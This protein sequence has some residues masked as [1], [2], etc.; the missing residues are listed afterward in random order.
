MPP[1]N[2]IINFFNI[3]EQSFSGGRFIRLTLGKPANP[4]ADLKNVYIKPVS[5][6]SQIVLSFVY[7]HQT[8]DITKNFPISEALAIL[9]SLLGSVFLHAILFTQDN[10]I[11]VLFNKKRVSKIVF[12][13]PTQS[14]L[15]AFTHDH[16]KTRLISTEGNYYLQQLG[17]T[18][19]KFEV[20]P[21]DAG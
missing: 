9:K 15:Q 19:T 2:E 17:L 3:F 1:E 16:Q 5:I 18:N 6:K 11:Q 14:I 20:T 7:R 21:K 13:K 12:S 4:G 10:D 8:K